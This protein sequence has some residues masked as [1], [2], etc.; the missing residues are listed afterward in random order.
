MYVCICHGVSDSVIEQAVENGAT[1]MKALNTELNVASQCGKCCQCAKKILNKK[2]MQIAEA[3][4]Q[5]A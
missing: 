5:V 4:P 1:T 2:L 3:S